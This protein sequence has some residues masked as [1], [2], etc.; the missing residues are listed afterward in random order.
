MKEEQLIKEYTE[1]EIPFIS[2]DE[3]EKEK[4]IDDGLSCN[5]TKKLSSL[6]K[7]TIS[8]PTSTGKTNNDY[9]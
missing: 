6:V 8:E 3:K 7:M 4:L 5:E 9:I 2:E 1:D